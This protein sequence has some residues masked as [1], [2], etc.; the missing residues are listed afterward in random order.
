MYTAHKNIIFNQVQISKT[1][2][3]IIA[4]L[5]LIKKINLILAKKRKVFLLFSRKRHR[6]IV[7]LLL[8]KSY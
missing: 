3:H 7:R 5:L 6:R 8:I 4:R 1:T 2:Y